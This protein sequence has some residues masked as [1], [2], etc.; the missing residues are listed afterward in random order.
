MQAAPSSRRP[1]STRLKIG[2]ALAVAVGVAG[3]VLL[4]RHVN[5][6]AEV[7][8]RAAPR[9]LSV[10]AVDSEGSGEQE[11]RRELA[12][13]RRELAGLR[14]GQEALFQEAGAPAKGAPADPG[15]S[16]PMDDTKSA[17]KSLEEFEAREQEALRRLD[18]RL[19]S[20]ARDTAWSEPTEAEIRGAIE[21]DVSTR[22][23]S[24]ECGAT[25]CRAEVEHASVESQERFLDQ[26]LDSPATRGGA[27]IKPSAGE[28]GSLPALVYVF[29]D[30]HNSS[31]REP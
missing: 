13:L 30:G 11:L 5:Q 23:I 28:P 15:A 18:A 7:P 4:A 27:F 21:G 12:A 26:V 20:E 29:R 16:R 9:S 24:L 2:A 3:A 25:L 14:S 8:P 17:P 31:P 19:A 1:E 6:G 22:L 10:R